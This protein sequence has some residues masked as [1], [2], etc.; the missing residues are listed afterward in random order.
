MNYLS[1]LTLV[2]KKRNSNTSK[3]EIPRSIKLII[4]VLGVMHRMLTIR[5]CQFNSCVGFWT[6]LS[7]RVFFTL[8][9]P[10]WPWILN[11]TPKGP[12]EISRRI[13]WANKKFLKKKFQQLIFR[14]W[15]EI[16]KNF[17]VSLHFSS[18]MIILITFNIP[19]SFVHYS[20]SGSWTKLSKS[21]RN[22]Y[23]N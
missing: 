23:S 5:K 20:I 10:R 1:F 19:I 7:K 3:L 9:D 2:S 8:P 22:Y 21:R 6:I 14:K 17:L 4:R 16:S 15:K 13:F 11:L 18:S 12:P